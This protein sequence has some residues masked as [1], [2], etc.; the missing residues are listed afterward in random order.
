MGAILLRKG[1][2]I[3]ITEAVSKAATKRDDEAVEVLELLVD[4]SGNTGHITEAVF[5]EIGS[6][7]VTDHHF[8]V[9][10]EESLKR[11][12]EPSETQRTPWTDAYKKGYF[13]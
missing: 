12:R 4:W 9:S 7:H 11:K 6:L 2:E 13:V 3:E 5:R 8:H 1:H 10:I